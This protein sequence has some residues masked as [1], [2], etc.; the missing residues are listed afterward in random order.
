MLGVKSSKN[1]G[2]SLKTGR[3]HFPVQYHRKQPN[4]TAN[5]PK[6]VYPAIKLNTAYFKHR[7]AVTQPKES[8]TV[9]LVKSSENQADSLHTGRRPFFGAMRL[10]TTQYYSKQT[11]HV[12]CA[13][14]LSPTCFSNEKA[15]RLFLVTLNSKQRNFVANIQK[16]IFA[17][18]RLEKGYSETKNEIAVSL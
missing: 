11:K 1:Q 3:K 7:K 18:M 15:K 2:D 8:R 9:V 17:T 4:F 5:K 12:F 14:K 6:H 10:K 16:R 13:L